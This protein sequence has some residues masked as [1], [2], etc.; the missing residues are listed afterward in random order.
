MEKKVSSRLYV[1]ILLEVFS[2]NV[3]GTICHEQRPFR[4]Y[5]HFHW[6]K[7]PKNYLSSTLHACATNG[8]SLVTMNQ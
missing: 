4:L 3:P 7:F 2:R 8:V 1:R 5:L 6:G